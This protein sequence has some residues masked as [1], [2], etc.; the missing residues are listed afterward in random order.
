MFIHL[1]LIAGIFAPRQNS[2]M[3][4]RMQGLHT[5][6]KYFRETGKLLDRGNW[7]SGSLECGPGAARRDYLDTMTH[8][9]MREFD[10][11]GLV[12]HPNQGASQLNLIGHWSIILLGDFNHRSS[13]GAMAQNIR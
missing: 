1:A 5:A 9:G 3:N 8:E 11:S 7:D 13:V 6:A 10:K 2:A 12:G 4:P